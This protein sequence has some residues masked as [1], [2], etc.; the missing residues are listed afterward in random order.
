ML[1]PTEC[2]IKCSAFKFVL[3]ES[4]K[5]TMKVAASRRRWRPRGSRG[6]PQTSGLT[7]SS[8]SIGRC[9]R[10]QTHTCRETVNRA[11]RSRLWPG[12][13][14]GRSRAQASRRR[15][16]SSENR[17]L[18]RRHCRHRWAPR[19]RAPRTRT[20]IVWTVARCRSR[21]KLPVCTGNNSGLYLVIIIRT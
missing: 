8:A 16:R 18:R 15:G 3:W 6:S 14:H 2:R 20:Q 7:S 4:Q 19:S 1:Y 13:R 12:C 5:R 9:V 17:S 21:L 10:S 11:H